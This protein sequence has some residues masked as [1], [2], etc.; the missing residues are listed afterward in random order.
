M[1]RQIQ[2]TKNFLNSKTTTKPFAGIVLGTGLGN[3][4]TEIKNKT[5]IPY[6][7]IPNFPISTVEGHN[8]N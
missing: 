1:L 5:A 4:S 7:E 6:S 3:L 8:E 2:E